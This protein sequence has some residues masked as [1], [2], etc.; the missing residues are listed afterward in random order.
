[1]QVKLPVGVAQGSTPEEKCE[2]KPPGPP[3]WVCDLAGDATRLGRNLSEYVP[4]PLP[5][6]SEASLSLGCWPYQTHHLIPW[7]QLAKHPVTQWLKETPEK[8]IPQMMYGDTDY[9][10]DSWENGKYMP[11]AS[12]LPEWQGASTKEK[13]RLR[14]IVMEKAQ[15]QLHQG[16][17]SF[18]A[19]VAGEEGYKTR[20]DKYLKEVIRDASGHY[21]KDPP[22]P[23]CKDKKQAGK[24]A[25]RRNVVRMV[26]GVSQKLEIDII[27]GKIFVSRQAAEYAAV[28]GVMR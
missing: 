11:Y 28:G 19:Y 22:C 17:H 13:L 12:I 2:L 14:R 15:M 27:K 23:D 25:P 20:V 4:E 3:Q 5:C 21:K 10:V 6:P 26:H 9:C 8:G 18:K 16:P 24:V 1:M 7:Q